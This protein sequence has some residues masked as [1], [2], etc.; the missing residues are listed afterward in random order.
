MESLQS[1]IQAIGLARARLIQLMA[2][3]FRSQSYLDVRARLP[4][5]P[6]PAVINGSVRNHQ[7][8]VT[9]IQS[10]AQGTAILLDAVPIELLS[11]PETES[12]WTLFQS[13]ADLYGAE[14]HIAVPRIAGGM[15]GPEAVRTRLR[16]IGIHARYV[17][18]V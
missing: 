7:P 10:D 16:A 8:D 15:L 14:F 4:G 17:W 12:R 3:F 13:A 6:R 9:A 18:S 2:E 11:D 1:E 5:Y